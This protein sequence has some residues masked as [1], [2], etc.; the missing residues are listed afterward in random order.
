MLIKGSDKKWVFFVLYKGV[1]AIRS[2]PSSVQTLNKV[3]ISVIAL[4]GLTVTKTFAHVTPHLI[5]S[6]NNKYA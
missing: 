2:Q 1:I 5:C 6:I 3:H 4:D